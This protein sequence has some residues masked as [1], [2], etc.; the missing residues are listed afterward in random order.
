MVKKMSIIDYLFGA[1]QEITNYWL[2]KQSISS[3]LYNLKFS[4]SK[5]EKQIKYMSRICLS[6]SDDIHKLTEELEIKP[7]DPI[8]FLE[9]IYFS[10]FVVCISY[11]EV[12]NKNIMYSLYKIRQMVEW[13]IYKIDSH[14]RFNLN[15]ISG[16][17]NEPYRYVS[18]M[19]EYEKYFPDNTDA[20]FGLLYVRYCSS[21]YLNGE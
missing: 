7:Q 9:L 13:F 11:Y 6:F 1:N 3:F 15:I 12:K 10:M 21:G 4:N 2:A 20:M 19:S 14:I 5:E 16:F 17:Y 18:K 8:N